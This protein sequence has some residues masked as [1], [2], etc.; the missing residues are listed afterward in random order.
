MLNDAG[1]THNYWKR[2]YTAEEA[3]EAQAAA[4]TTM[5]PTGEYPMHLRLFV[6]PQPAPTVLIGS[7]ILSYGLHLLRIQLPFYRAGYNVLQFDFPGLGQ[8]GGPRGGCTVDDFLQA[9]RDAVDYAEQRFDGPLYAMG[10]GEDGVTCYYV[11]STMPERIQAISVHNLFEYG[12]PDSVQGQ[13]PHWLVRA[14]AGGLAGLAAVR[15]TTA[16]PGH[17]S[18]PWEWIYGGPGDDAMIELLKKDPLAL[19]SID[20]R[21]MSSILAAR[22]AEV[23]FEECRL[24][25]QLIAT[26]QNKV[27]P[28]ELV[29]RNFERLSGPKD[30]IIMHG[31]PQWETN[32]T[33]AEEYC[34]H[35]T[36]W[37]EERGAQPVR[38]PRA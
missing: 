29:M 11:T 34:A 22:P 10:V 14:K 32:R 35:V 5:I 2:Y 30:L 9:W 38:G 20:L 7:S 25:V 16:I 31:R 8:S 13:G 26:D 12:E 4:R 6:Q 21:M 19:R 17:K 1:L 3:T 23:P 24:P 18:V 36:R 28:F 33:F 15:P 27:C 37:F